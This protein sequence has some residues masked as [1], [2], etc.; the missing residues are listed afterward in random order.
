MLEV[1]NYP[2]RILPDQK[3]LVKL[4]SSA[5][6]KRLEPENISV[7]FVTLSKIQELN[8]KYRYVDS[9]TDVLSFNYNTED[10]L[11]E[12]YVCVEY[13]KEKRPEIDLV[14]EVCRLIIHGILHLYEFD[15]K[16][17]F[18]DI[19]QPNLENMFVIQ[20]AILEEVMKK[21]KQ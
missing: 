16:T 4:I 8:N 15:H 5:V 14:E 7:I 18:I 19:N 13:I 6:K 3:I 17:E 11:G 12:V 21:L 20:E 9:A 10:L 1:F 2:K